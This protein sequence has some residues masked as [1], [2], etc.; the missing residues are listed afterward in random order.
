MPK[1]RI[2]KALSGFYYVEF[3]GELI[4]CRGRG[5][6]FVKKKLLL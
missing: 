4:Q 6:F 3:E 1:G 2:V 5:E